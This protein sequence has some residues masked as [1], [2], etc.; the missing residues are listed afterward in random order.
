[1]A[2]DARPGNP[3]SRTLR[4]IAALN[5]DA[6]RV[7]FTSGPSSAAKYV[8]YTHRMYTGYGLPWMW[9]GL[10]WRS[11][12]TVPQIPVQKLFPEIDFTHSPE[13]IHPFPRGL[14]TQPHELMILAHVV[15]LMQPKRVI[16][17]GTAEGRTTLNLALHVPPDGEVVT[18]DFPP[19]PGQNDVGFF[20][21]DQPLKS[22]IKQIFEGVDTWNSE[23]YRASAEIVFCDACDQPDGLS[24]ET[25]Q[26]FK[27]V[28]PGGVI[29][30]HDYSSAE[31]PTKYWN[32]IATELPVKHLEGTTL[33]CLRVDDPA[34]YEKM[35]K[36]AAS[37]RVV[38]S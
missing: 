28:K 11:D 10:P 34:V 25:A 1:M 27:V 35:Q 8:T 18:L 23:P 22:K 7:F 16:E 20:Y 5:L 33:L 2:D 36:M 12:L 17:F 4:G 13:L 15:N 26:A 37:G 21:W 24:A 30:R 32:A 3:V 19:V 29:F 6:L 31:G 14:S 9:S 38:P